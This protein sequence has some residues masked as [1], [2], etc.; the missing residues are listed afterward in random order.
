MGISPFAD[1]AVH[2]DAQ[3]VNQRDRQHDA[4]ERDVDVE[5][6][7]QRLARHAFDVDDDDGRD[8]ERDG[9]QDAGEERV[10]EVLLQWAHGGSSF[11]LG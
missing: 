2:D 6:L 5:E 11:P 3:Q 10:A 8:G 1:E 4:D 7:P 9:G